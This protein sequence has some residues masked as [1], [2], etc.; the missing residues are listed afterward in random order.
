LAGTVPIFVGQRNS[1]PLMKTVIPLLVFVLW[2]VPIRASPLISGQEKP[3]A[4]KPATSLVVLPVVYYTPE[5]RL[6]FGAGGIYIFPLKGAS[7]AARPSYFQTIAVYTQNKQFTL[8]L[9]PNLFLRNETLLINSL[10]ELKK[11]P[12]KFWGIGSDAPDSAEEDFTPAQQSLS[13]SFQKKVSRQISIYV[14]LKY[15]LEHYNFLKFEADGQLAAGHI[16]GCRGGILSGL[17]LVLNLDS[18][19]NIFSAF[20]GNYFQVSAQLFSRFLAGDYN[21][22]KFKA[23]L[24]CYLPLWQAHVLALQG[25]FQ[26]VPGET[27][28]MAL[29]PLGGDSLMRGF[30]LGRY[31]D[32]VLLAAQVEYRLPL[33]WRFGLVGFAGIGGVADRIG[34]LSAG[35]FK[36]SCGLGLRFRLN[37]EGAKLRLDFGYGKE[38]S[39]VYFTAGEAF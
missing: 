10:L 8:S 14:G 5:T 9:E 6:A 27:P 37:R 4:E 38:T 22:F 7:L 34:C 25:V 3:S 39:G 18:R 23:D 26:A 35:R 30:Y 28:F 24:R 1:R 31:R 29:P 21:Y 16:T 11:Y 12:D 36:S 19:D 20:R 13:I 32:K 33:W 15:D 17:G 2:T